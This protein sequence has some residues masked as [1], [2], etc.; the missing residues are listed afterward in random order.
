M[1]V[2]ADG[3]G[4]GAF[5]KVSFGILHFLRSL[6]YVADVRLDA[7]IGA[8]EAQIAR[9]EERNSP[10]RL[11]GDLVAFLG[12]VNGFRLSWCVAPHSTEAQGGN[13]DAQVC[14]VGVLQVNGLG[15][16]VR[17]SIN[18][19][20]RDAALAR[21]AAEGNGKEARG[22]PRPRHAAGGGAAAA[23]AARATAAEGDC[24]AMAG[25][26]QLSDSV[27]AFVL[28]H[29]PDVGRVVLLYRNDDVSARAHGAD[30]ASFATPEVWF[31]DLGCGWSRIARSFTRY[32]R[33]LLVHLGIVGWQYAYSPAGI[34]PP[35]EQWMRLY[36]PQRLALDLRN[37][38]RPPGARSVPEVTG[39]ARESPAQRCTAR[40]EGGGVSSD[41]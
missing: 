9:W 24:G 11:P 10:Y 27:A 26:N 17:L 41:L 31:Q 36:C 39:A 15:N 29:D 35:T 3:D 5:E 21:P 23:T 12:V 33:L 25:P 18:S 40:G 16:S 22:C 14:P 6:P 2:V 37:E 34:P 8:S 1:V 20:E 30:A 28:Q 13:Q 19:F 7:P 4:E 38:P 32:F